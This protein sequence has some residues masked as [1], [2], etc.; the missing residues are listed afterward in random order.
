MPSVTAEQQWIA[1]LQWA[2]PQLHM[3]WRGFR[4]VRSQVRK[5]VHQRMQFLQLAGLDAYRLFLR[6][7][8][9]EWRVLD[10]LCR[11]TIS[12]FY[13]DAGIY[14]LLAE[15]LLPRLVQQA[16]RQGE[17]ALRLWS[18]GCASGEEPYSLS[19]LWAM[20]LHTRF[21]ASA[22]QILATDTD[23]HLLQRARTACY[24]YSNVKDLPAAWRQAAFTGAAGE[25]CL[26][27]A[28][29]Q[30]VLFVE[31]D[32]RTAIPARALHLILCR[33]LVYTYFDTALQHEITQ[34][35]YAALQPGGLLVIGIHETLPPGIAGFMP[36]IPN[37][38]IYLKG[39]SKN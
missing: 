2:L 17:A 22:L 24:P 38:G 14:A 16:R 29:K 1:F 3:Q 20:Q 34:R 35:L 15:Q 12:R 5:R 19:I 11:I 13:R 28:F 18:A 25:Y 32:I 7:H 21:P 33:N 39:T 9:E 37:R 23:P 31:H 8:P 10:A 4:K 26:R 30:P 6:Q 36:L 27:N